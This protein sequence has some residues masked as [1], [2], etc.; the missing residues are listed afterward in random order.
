MVN[1][2]INMIK[3]QLRPS[4]I[5]DSSILSLFEQISREAFTPE[6]FKAIAY[7]DYMIPLSKDQVMLSP[8]LEAKILDV[9]QIQPNE[10]VLEVGTGTGY[11]TTLLAKKAQHV[12]S[13]DYHDQYTKQIHENLSELNITNVTLQLGNA[14]HGWE[15]QQPYNVIVITGS[16]DFLPQQFKQQLTVGGRI[17]VVINNGP[18]MQAHL[19]TRT[20]QQSWE[21]QILFETSLPPFAEALKKSKFV[22]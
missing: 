8:I 6:P 16:L 3:Q 18:A 12:Y 13:V 20:S 21:D 11:L 4:G 2:K 15:K 10:K 5:L 22:F 17:F 1:A 7:A 14:T 19:I 9:L